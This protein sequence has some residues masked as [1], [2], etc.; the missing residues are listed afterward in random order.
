[1]IKWYEIWTKLKLK[2]QFY[3]ILIKI[4]EQD[5]GDKIILESFIGNEEREF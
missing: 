5:K 2:S 4:H 1:M 3:K